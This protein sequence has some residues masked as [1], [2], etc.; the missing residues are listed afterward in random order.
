MVDGN[1][2]DNRF[3]KMEGDYELG[4]WIL[5]GS[6]KKK[7]G[8]SKKKKNSLWLFDL[9]KQFDTKGFA[10]KIKQLKSFTENRPNTSSKSLK[11]F[12]FN[13]NG[14]SY[15]IDE[16]PIFHVQNSI[17]LIPSSSK[18]KNEEDGESGSR[19][20]ANNL[21]NACFSTGEFRRSFI[22]RERQKTNT[23][24][25]TT[26][27]NQ[28]KKKKNMMMM[29]QQQQQLGS[30]AVGGGVQTRATRIHKMSCKPVSSLVPVLS[31]SILDDDDDDYDGDDAPL[32]SCEKESKHL[33]AAA[34]KISRKIKG[35]STTMGKKKRKKSNGDS[36][37]S[38]SLSSTSK[39]RK[40]EQQQQHQQAEDNSSNVGKKRKKKKPKQKRK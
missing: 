14:K 21:K 38:S 3:E 5:T 2:D 8:S 39:K 10:E 36:R 24:L 22:V 18:K 9:P 11:I 30:T 19:T 35:E 12:E 26:R 16:E 23:V 28:K 34:T 25:E 27:S 31:S 6:S 7:S 20:K 40:K 15:E 29:K 32:Q 17:A 1:D 4:Q 33:T 13:L 37:L